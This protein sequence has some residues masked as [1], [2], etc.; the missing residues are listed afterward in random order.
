M[1]SKR[2]ERHDNPLHQ[3]LN[4][5]QFNHQ[6]MSTRH[7]GARDKNYADMLKNHTVSPNKRVKTG[8]DKRRII[9]KQHSGLGFASSDE[10]REN[11]NRLFNEM[12]AQDEEQED[13]Q[14]ENSINSN[15]QI[16]GKSEGDLDES[17]EEQ[18]DPNQEDERNSN[19][20]DFARSEQDVQSDEELDEDGLDEKS[21]NNP[22]TQ[23]NQLKHKQIGFYQKMGHK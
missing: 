5:G 9:G 1:N 7:K 16:E 8:S 15:G 13:E 20:S 12:E 4:H 19:N 14:N 6:R 10:D 21:L 23:K 3:G 22:E 17:K 2:F 18:A 11:G